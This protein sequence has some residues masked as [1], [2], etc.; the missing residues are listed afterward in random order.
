MLCV[1]ASSFHRSAHGKQQRPIVPLLPHTRVH[2]NVQGRTV[3]GRYKTTIRNAAILPSYHRYLQQRFQWSSDTLQNIDWEVLAILVSSYDDHRPTI[4]KH[5]HGIAPTGKY[6]HRYNIHT[7]AKCPSCQCEEE[8]NDHMIQCLSST[9]AQWRTDTIR[10]LNASITARN[11]DQTILDILCKGIQCSFTIDRPYVPTDM[12]PPEYHP[13][14]NDQN[15]IGWIQLFRGRWAK[16]WKQCYAEFAV[17]GNP[18][19]ATAEASKWV[20][21]CGRLLLS[22][23]CTLWRLRNEDQ[24]NKTREETTERLQNETWSRLEELYR[25]MPQIMPVDRQLY[26]FATALEHFGSP[27]PMETKLEWCHDVGP[28][29]QA[30]SHQASILGIQSNTSIQHYYRAQTATNIIPAQPSS[31]NAA[32]HAFG[33]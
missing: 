17:K 23:W 26:P 9:R 2:L 5:L 33:S 18:L 19:H 11:R 31:S 7:P 29:I 8:T 22:Q 20:H 12:Y 21:S 16:K 15:A 24:H 27:A 10:K 13:L 25:A 28:V 32:R 1:L 30:S 3:T 6:V 14:I 4:V